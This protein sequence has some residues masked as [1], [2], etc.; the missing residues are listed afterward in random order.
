MQR[1]VEPE[2]MDDKVQ[3]EAY[4]AANFEQADK[5]IVDAFDLHFPSTE[6]NGNILD[7]GCGPGNI[8]FQ[9]AQRFTNGHIVGIDGSTEMIKLANQEMVKL[10]FQNRITLITDIIPG[11]AIPQIQYSAIV[12]NS[13]LHHLHRP[14]V[15]WNTIKQ[16]SSSDTK[17]LIVDLFRPNSEEDASRI[18]KNYSSDEAEILQRDF[19]Y[20]LLA[21]FTPEEIEQQLIN[22][23]LTQL[24]IKIITDRH[25]LIF[26]V[27]G[28]IS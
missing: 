10:G 7:L 1:T 18:V 19:Y 9:M 27:K 24:K 23:G 16:Y 17:I 3:A 28:N 25:L 13:F 20:S 22:A 14:E 6:I 12:S 15:L 21:A 26:G 2:L 4:A 8:T 11:T 5:L